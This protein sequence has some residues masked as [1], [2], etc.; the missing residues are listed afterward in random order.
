M[1]CYAVFTCRIPQESRL[2]PLSGIL[3]SNIRSV[4]FRPYQCKAYLRNLRTWKQKKEE[5]N[6]KMDDYLKEF[7]PSGFQKVIS[8]LFK[9]HQ[10]YYLHNQT[11][12]NLYFPQFNK[13]NPILKLYQWGRND[14]LGRWMV[15]VYVCAESECW[16]PWLA[17]S[18][19]F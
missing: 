17:D 12:V 8:Y 2:L 16:L 15:C 13:N 18:E 6:R 5:W 7:Q 10:C 11:Q 3:C 4:K 19:K 9:L 1:F 14:F